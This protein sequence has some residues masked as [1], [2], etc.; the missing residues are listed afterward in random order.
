LLQTSQYKH[1]WAL[2]I[3]QK[4]T[5]KINISCTP[6]NTQRSKMQVVKRHPFRACCTQSDNVFDI[7]KCR[8]SSTKTHQ[9]GK[10]TLWHNTY[11]SWCNQ[12]DSTF[13][14]GIHLL[15]TKNIKSSRN[16]FCVSWF[17]WKEFAKNENH[18]DG[19]ECNMRSLSN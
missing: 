17:F 2:N 9:N 8:T 19:I 13:L 12:M 5:T 16:S 7:K 4:F 15:I 3:G 6:F 14:N 10:T 18:D 1:V 11:A